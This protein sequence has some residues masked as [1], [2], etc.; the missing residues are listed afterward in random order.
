VPDST[1]NNDVIRNFT[2]FIYI[3]KILKIGIP[4]DI[5]ANFSVKMDVNSDGYFN[6]VD[7]AILKNTLFS[8]LS[9]VL[10]DE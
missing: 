4:P 3:C 2:E 10:T 8:R 7:I 9:N 5:S 6:A 1:L